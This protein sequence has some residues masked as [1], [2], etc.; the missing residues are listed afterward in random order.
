MNNKGFFAISIVYSFF[1]VF[2][3][4]MVAILAQA[5]NSRVL[6]SKVKNE[7]RDD[8]GNSQ[9]LFV[10]NIENGY[11]LGDTIFLAGEE[12]VVLKDNG[13]SY[14]L[15]LN[16]V[17][18]KSEIVR[19]LGLSLKAD[20]K[21]EN[22]VTVGYDPAEY[23]GTC[24]EESKCSLRACR[25]TPANV[26]FCYYYTNDDGHTVFYNKPTWKLDYTGTEFGTTIV[27]KAVNVW[28]DNHQGLQRL[29]KAQKFVGGATMPNINDNTTL[30]IGNQISGYIRLPYSYEFDGLPILVQNKLKE[31][32]PIHLTDVAGGDKIKLYNNGTVQEVNSLTPALIR[33]VI[34]VKK[35][36]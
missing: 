22:G 36:A 21:V 27:S 35:D 13:T 17:L 23:Y 2:L 15:I 6:V 11:M 25:K 16:R 30:G 4:L 9:G 34:E 8:L 3:A 32:S 7:I 14:V 29:K 10:G 26:E 28:F 33:P 5:V 20:F 24:T 19:S 1:I 12:W 18:T 31:I